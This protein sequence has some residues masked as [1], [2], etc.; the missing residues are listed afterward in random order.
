MADKK[1]W[2][3]GQAMKNFDDLLTKLSKLASQFLSMV[4]GTAR[5]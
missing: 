5:C 3:V 4:S 2:N 1:R